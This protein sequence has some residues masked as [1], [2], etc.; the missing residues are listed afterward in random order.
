LNVKA[1][2][3]AA[4]FIDLVGTL[5]S[6]AVFFFDMSVP[7]M[8]H[9]LQRSLSVFTRHSD[10]EPQPAYYAQAQGVWLDSLEGP[11]VTD[12]II[13]KHLDAGQI[14]IGRRQLA[15]FTHHE[16]KRVRRTTVIAI[17]HEK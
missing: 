3:M 15:P 12:D 9:Y 11:W 4:K 8:R 17:E 5:S 13:R 14:W 1:D 6:E 16:C 2:G 10:V 7:D